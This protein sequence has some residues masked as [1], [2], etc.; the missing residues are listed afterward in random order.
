MILKMS[1]Y[2]MTKANK[3]YGIIQNDHNQEYF[4]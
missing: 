3:A 4:F 1:L 2:E